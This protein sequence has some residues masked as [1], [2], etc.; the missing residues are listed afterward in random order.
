MKVRTI[1]TG[2]FTNKKCTRIKCRRLMIKKKNLSFLRIISKL[3]ILLSSG[4][5][6]S[7]STLQL[8]MQ[9]SKNSHPNHHLKNRLP[10]R[11]RKIN[12][13]LIRLTR[14]PFHLENNPKT[15]HNQLQPSNFKTVSSKS[16]TKAAILLLSS[17]HLSKTCKTKTPRIGRHNAPILTF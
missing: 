14:L 4:E 9:P 5:R 8:L 1:R 17:V 3:T 13:I 12:K 16:K 15:V 7:A 6:I 10:R 11:K 2:T